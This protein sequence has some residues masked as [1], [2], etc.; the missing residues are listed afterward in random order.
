MSPTTLQN[1]LDK[2]I[3]LSKRNMLICGKGIAVM[4][5]QYKTLDRLAVSKD[6]FDS[7]N[8]QPVFVSS[9]NQ[10]TDS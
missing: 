10:R 8:W 1:Q 2:E 3:T 9:V 7:V 6:F 5:V 4:Y